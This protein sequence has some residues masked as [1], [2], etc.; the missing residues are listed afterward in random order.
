[1]QLCIIL[2]FVGEKNVDAEQP[3]TF[4]GKPGYDLLYPGHIPSNFFQKTLLSVGAA[5][6][7]V[8]SPWRG[9]M[10]L[11]LLHCSVNQPETFVIYSGS[12]F[13]MY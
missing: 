3:S 1:M 10:W 9:G 11:F 4:D 6:V 13:K 5:A 8:T 2:I 7:A 12:V